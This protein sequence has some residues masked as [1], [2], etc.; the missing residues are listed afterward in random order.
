[1]V[2]TIAGALET[3]RAAVHWYA[4]ILAEGADA[5]RRQVVHVDVDIVG[6]DEIEVAVIV[7]I[8]ESRARSP[9]A[10]VGDAS[11]RGDIGKR[12]IVVVVVERG[13]VEAGDVDVFPA[14]VVVVA[15][16]HAVS[17]AAE[18]EAGFRGNVGERSVV[19][20]VV[21]LRGMAFAG[22]VILDRG[23]IN[24]EDVHPSVVVVV[25]GGGA[26]TLGFYDVE[27]FSAPAV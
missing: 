26:S 10:G 8:T 18:I 20:V 2:E 11:F 25:E 15:D 3:A 4:A 13:V 7:V 17:P 27:F 9:A 23:A 6:D 22:L 19:V 5:E 24:K 16:G 12:S 14:I 21:E 1:M